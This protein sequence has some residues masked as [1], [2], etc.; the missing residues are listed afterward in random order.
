MSEVG[1]RSLK[2]NASAVVAVATAG[3]T[4]TITDRGRPVALLAPIPESALQ[5][6]LAAGQGRRARRSLTSLGAP[7]AGRSL[8]AELA[9]QRDEERY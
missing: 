9:V 3:E 4:V 5:A 2:Q 7:A 6:L 8:S 1:I